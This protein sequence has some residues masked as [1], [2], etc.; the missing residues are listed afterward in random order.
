MPLTVE[1][2]FK[3]DDRGVTLAD[4]RDYITGVDDAEGHSDLQDCVREG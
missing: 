4:L 1:K 3:Q 2:S